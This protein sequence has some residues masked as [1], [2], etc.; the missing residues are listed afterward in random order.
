MMQVDEL[1]QVVYMWHG[2][3]HHGEQGSKA[4]CLAAVARFRADGWHC[5]IERWR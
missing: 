4:G 2:E 3:R 5:W 1:W